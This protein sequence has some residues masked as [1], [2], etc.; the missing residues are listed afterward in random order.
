MWCVHVLHHRVFWPHQLHSRCYHSS[1]RI[2]QSCSCFV[3][4]SLSRHYSTPAPC[5]H[6]S[7]FGQ[8]VKAG[9][10]GVTVVSGQLDMNACTLHDC[11]YGIE[12]G[13]DAHACITNSSICFT[14]CALMCEGHMA[15]TGCKIWGNVATWHGCATPTSAASLVHMFRITTYLILLTVPGE[16]CSFCCCKLEAEFLCRAPCDGG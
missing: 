16:Q 15:L 8:D 14:E 1:R 4:V 3:T 13:V 6:L 2:R 9:L 7:I 12:V 5:V 10:S 11:S